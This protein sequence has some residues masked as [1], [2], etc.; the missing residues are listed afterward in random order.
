LTF[1]SRRGWWRQHRMPGSVMAV[2]AIGYRSD[3]SLVSVA[4]S[5]LKVWPQNRSAVSDGAE[6]VAR[7][8]GRVVWSADR[9]RVAVL[10]WMLGGC[11]VYDSETFDL[12]H[13]FVP[14]HGPGHVLAFLPD[15]LEVIAAGNDGEPF[16]CRIMDGVEQCRF[17]KTIAVTSGLVVPGGAHF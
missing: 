6:L 4:A 7:P 1:T 13:E 8:W 15:G 3:G 2:N 9:R 16:R 14:P 12:L 10:S 5:E 17:A 11:V